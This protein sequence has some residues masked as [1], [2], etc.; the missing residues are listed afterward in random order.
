MY[1]LTHLSDSERMRIELDKQASYTVWKVKNGKVGY[2]AFAE[3]TNSIEDDDEREFCQQ[4][5]IK[6]KSQ[7][8]VN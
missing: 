8:G 4:A 5:I 3:L 1:N 6:Y 2:E 7:M